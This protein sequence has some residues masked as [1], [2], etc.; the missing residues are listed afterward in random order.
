MPHRQR[1]G[2]CVYCRTNGHVTNDHVPPKCLFPPAV[3]VNLVTV[4]AC[5][6]CHNEFK[7]DDEYFRVILSLR[8]DLPEG[9]DADYI[10]DQTVKGLRDPKGRNFL[11]SIKSKAGTLPFYSP[12]GAYVGN[13]PTL[14]VDAGRLRS[15]AERI[16]CGLFSKYLRHAVPATHEV[17][18]SVLDL[19]K[20]DSAL[21][22]PEVAAMLSELRVRGRRHQF[23]NVLDVWFVS[24]VDDLESTMWFVNLHRVF[25][26]IGFTAPRDG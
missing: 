14:Q 9:E 7:L 17:T 24:T 15:T 13:V 20:D 23:G 25:A 3:R 6:K 19:Q 2:E 16:V 26:F 1:I 21:Y 18:V 11:A 8:I 22:S 4:N 5:P 10:R 12:S